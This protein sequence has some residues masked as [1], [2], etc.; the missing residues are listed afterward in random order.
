MPRK[1]VPNDIVDQVLIQCRRRYAL[2]FG[3]DGRTGVK[4]GQIA[5][6]DRDNANN[7]A[8]N[9][10]WLCLHHHEMYDRRSQQSR[11][12]TERELLTHR[13]AL[14]EYLKALPAAWADSPI[15]L[16]SRRRAL[17][18]DVYDRKILIYRNARDLI[19]KAAQNG[20][21]EWPELFAFNKATDEA[22]FMLELTSTSTYKSC[23]ASAFTVTRPTKS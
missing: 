4:E 9:L 8:E 15:K 17:Q 20:T 14:L 7:R 2:C 21:I 1:Q 6:A 5:H 11:R 12:F 16:P 13:A 10:V 22:I 3:L 18:S 23:S 19:I